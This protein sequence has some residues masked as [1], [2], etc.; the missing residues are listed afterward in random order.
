M[1]LLENHSIGKCRLYLIGISTQYVNRLENCY[2]TAHHVQSD[3]SQSTSFLCRK[4]ERSHFRIELEELENEWFIQLKYIDE[5]DL[6]E[7]DQMR[8]NFV[9]DGFNL[10][11]IDFDKMTGVTS[12]GISSADEDGKVGND[13]LFNLVVE[14]ETFD[15]STIFAKEGSLSFDA[16]TLTRINWNIYVCYLVVLP[17]HTLIKRS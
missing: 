1:E 17:N 10:N 11:I 8:P 12:T 9:D 7:K 2:F 15:M 13:V 6:D 4:Q 16:S 3:F 14:T 5:Y